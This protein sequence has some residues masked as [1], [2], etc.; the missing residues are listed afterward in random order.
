MECEGRWYTRRSYRRDNGVACII[1]ACAARA[2]VGVCREDIDELAFAFVAPLGT[3]DDRYFTKKVRLCCH[4]RRELHIP[5]MVALGSTVVD[6]Q[7]KEVLVVR[8]VAS[9]SDLITR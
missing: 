7:Q 8:S 4:S 1:S 9:R 6:V 2:D 3:K 5:L